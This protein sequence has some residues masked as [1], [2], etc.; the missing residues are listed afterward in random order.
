MNSASLSKTISAQWLSS[1]DNIRCEAW[2]AVTGLDYPFTRHEFLHALELSG[3]TTADTGW[4]AQ[5]LLL[6]QGEE[7]LAIM[8][9]YIKSHSYG[10]YVFDWAW[11]DA[12]QRHGLDY[13]PKLLA[14]IPFTPATGPRLCISPALSTDIDHQSLYQLA[15]QALVQRAEQLECSSAHI[16]FS[17]KAASEHWQA[18]D[19][20]QRQAPQYH[21]FNH[22]YSS[23]DDFLGRFSSRKRKDLRKE[24]RRVE[25]QGL[26]LEVFSGEDI[27]PEHWRIF[28]PFYQLTYAKRSGHGGY[29]NRTFFELIGEQLREQLVLVL[30]KDGEDWVAGALN[31]R[32]SQTLYGRYWGCS[33][34]YDYLHFEACY[35]QGIDY[36]IR[37]G[38]QRFDSGAQGEHKIQRGFE[39]I[40]TYSSHWLAHLGFRDA[41]AQF[42]QR[43]SPEIQRYLTEAASALPFKQGEPP[44]SR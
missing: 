1:L 17:D 42:L 3:A 9:C 23:F 21:W 31:L 18:Q 24:R 44:G 6:K 41:V 34:E 4:Q 30:A 39:P 13:Y 16:L 11:A 14:A 40:T 27:R 28:Y 26:S 7:I 33:R 19:L 22:G 10:E 32:D 25:E 35:Y 8:P 29:L 37:H 5:H 20:L 43:E 38:L 15:S 2:N 12:Y 36:C